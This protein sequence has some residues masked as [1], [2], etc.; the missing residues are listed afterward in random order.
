MLSVLRKILGV[1]L[2]LF[3]LFALV[4]P[5]TPGAWIGLIGLELVGLGFLI[6][7]KVRTYL[8]TLKDKLLRRDPQT[9]NPSDAASV[10]ED[11][12]AP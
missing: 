12:P 7:K 6:P 5:F 11:P 2:I 8:E 9:K 3:G 4:T 1:I 10:R